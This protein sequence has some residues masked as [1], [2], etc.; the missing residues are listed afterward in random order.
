M[1]KI[2]LVITLAVVPVVV[3]CA[4]KRDENQH[5]YSENVSSNNTSYS[6][7]K[8]MQY[9]GYFPNGFYEYSFPLSDYSPPNWWGYSNVKHK[10][11]GNF[12]LLTVPKGGDKEAD[13]YKTYIIINGKLIGSLGGYNPK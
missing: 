7:Y 11:V 4:D 3:F 1:R 6:Y 10:K 2:L 9:E 12:E 8:E 13:G 5:V